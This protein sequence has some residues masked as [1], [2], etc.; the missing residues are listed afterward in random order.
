MTSD[1]R[2]RAVFHT[3]VIA[4]GSNL[5]DKVENC[6]YAVSELHRL[7]NSRVVDTSPFYRT[8]PVG[9]REQD[10]FINA[11]VMLKTS[12]KPHELLHALQAIQRRAG[13]TR[14]AV[15][16]GPRVLDLDIIFY[17]DAVIR[18]PELT[19][20]HPRMHERRF[21]LR[22]ICDM[23]SAILHPVLKLSVQT[24]LDRIEDETQVVE[25][26]ACD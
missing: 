23:D 14:Q 13:R 25:P 20:P 1:S 18:T 8:A 26:Y 15:R 6:R 9:Y 7:P 5:G 24:L 10:W 21:V 19:L 11:A 2:A 4:I 17:D 12:L 16:F 3:A 22:P